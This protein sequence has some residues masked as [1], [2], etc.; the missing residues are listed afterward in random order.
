M[1]TIL[2]SALIAFVLT[3]APAAMAAPAHSPY[4]T[5]MSKPYGGYAPNSAQGNR[6]FWD[7]VGQQ[8]D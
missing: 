4:F 7:Y 1:S 8:G 2:R 5:D 6:A 3:S